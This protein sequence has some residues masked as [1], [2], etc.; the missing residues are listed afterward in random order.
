MTFMTHQRHVPWYLWPFWAI[1]KLVIGIVAGDR[2]VGGSY[3]WPGFPDRRCGAD[4]HRGRGDRR[5]T[6]HY[7]WAISD[8]AGVILE[9]PSTLLVIKKIQPLL[10]LIRGKSGFMF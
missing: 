9:S 4:G 5:D 2:A 6:V 10:Y 7:F 1:W 8:G 3:P